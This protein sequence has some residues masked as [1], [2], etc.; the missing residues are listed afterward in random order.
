MSLS[1]SCVSSSARLSLLMLCLRRY[2]SLR[3]TV[4]TPPCEQLSS[5]LST[6]TI[7]PQSQSI[8][9]NRIPGEI[10]QR[11][12]EYACTATDCLDN[13]VS[14]ISLYHRQGYEYY[15]NIWM[16]L[17]STCRRVYLEAYL[18]PASVNEHVFWCYD[19]PPPPPEGLY[20]FERGQDFM[21]YILQLKLQTQ[22][23]KNAAQELHF[24]T[25]QFWLDMPGY[26]I[27]VSDNKTLWMLAAQSL[28]D[29]CRPKKI[30]MTIR[31]R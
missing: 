30:K 24:F 8:L 20:N 4:T 23:Q 26:G 28:A 18:L 19:G 27:G 3:S 22:E 16:D 6:K 13:P 29:E 1:K 25:Q 7:L 9:F 21:D 14:R 2:F 10:R 12:F 15:R 11:I 31:H 17:L 5:S